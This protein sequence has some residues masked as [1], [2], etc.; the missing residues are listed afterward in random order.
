M[1][2]TAGPLAMAGAYKPRLR[3]FEYM[4][5]NLGCA[6][7]DILHVSSSMR[8]DHMSAADIGIKMKAF[9]K[10]GHDPFNPAYGSVE[11]DD[12]NGLPGLVG[13]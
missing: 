4:I 5:D 1:E 9:V 13:L 2:N 6:P 8:Y 3:A 12:I 10:R 7:E 11:I